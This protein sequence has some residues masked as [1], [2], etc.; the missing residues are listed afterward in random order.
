MLKKRGKR[1]IIETMK[2][3]NEQYDIFC[4]IVL[5]ISRIL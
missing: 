2:K 4:K 5:V 3:I 1:C